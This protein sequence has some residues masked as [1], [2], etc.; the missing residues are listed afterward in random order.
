MTNLKAKGPSLELLI[1]RHQM[2]LIDC[3]DANKNT[4]LSEAAAGGSGETIEFLLKKGADVNSR[5]AFRRTPLYRA[6]FGG[7]L[8]AIQV[9]FSVQLLSLYCI[10]LID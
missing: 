2:A 7:H 8:N 1:L 6:A 9:G 5:G 4:P 3:E 10:Q